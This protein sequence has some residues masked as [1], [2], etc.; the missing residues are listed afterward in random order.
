LGDMESSDQG[1]GAGSDAFGG[2][3]DV[4]LSYSRDDKPQASEILRVL[5]A[6]GIS[7]WWDDM[8]EG[9]TP[10]LKDTEF[11]LEN[12]AT[13]VVLWSKISVN[14]H[15][16]AD[17]ATR[18]RDRGVLIPAT[19]DGTFPPLGFRQFQCLDLSSSDETVRTAQTQ[20][21][22]QAIK[23]KRDGDQ[24][25][26]VAQPA[27]T[28][29]NPSGA[30][31]RDTARA[32]DRRKILVGGGAAMVGAAGLAAWQGGMLDGLLGGDGAVRRVAVMPFDVVGGE[33]EQGAI[34]SNIAREVR[35]KL[36]RNPLLHVAARTSSA[37]LKDAG[38]TARE[39][40]QDLQVDYLL[41]GRASLKGERLDVSGELID[42]LNDRTLLPI[43]QV[44]PVGS[45]LT[46]QGQIASDVIR[47]LTN[48]DELEDKERAGGTDNI[49]AY[50]AFLQAEEL[51][52]AG[53]SEDTDRAALAK[54]DEAI[55]LDPDYAAALALR[56]RTI[57]LIGNL[58][59]EPGTIR[60]SYEEGAQSAREAIRRAPSYAGGHVTL[61]DIL[62]NRQLDMKAAR[63]PFATAAEL[64][65][66]DAGIL[67]GYA[68]YNARIG[69]FASA[70]E[71]IGRATAFDP[72]NAGVFRFAGN[73]EYYSGQYSAAIKRFTDALT[74][75][76]G[77][78]YTNYLIG[79]AQLALGEVAAAKTSFEKEPRF[80]WQKTGLSIAEHRLGNVAVAEA[81]FADLQERQGARS[82]YQYMQVLAQWGEE[83][84]ALDEMDS[85]W[86]ERD[87]GL[88]ELRNDPLL[89][90]LRSNPRFASMLAQIG[91]V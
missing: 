59:G 47:Q 81:H 87:S 54:F 34:L 74:I 31:Q 61:G 23:A 53:V 20:K 78:T 5:E 4:F 89:D 41:T 80:V 60:Q 30:L 17:E 10:F 67:A 73:I 88:I 38:K 29:V 2:A 79:I 7:V 1:K 44:G 15:W 42:G 27:P 19:I 35:T 22:I 16:V 63:E 64:G 62:A 50:D 33:A 39:I 12:A 86:A 72:L 70:R 37:A 32:F 36:S 58:Y 66:G 48:T 18:G 43:S 65:R 91:F 9:G 75:Q 24:G 6:A 69:E 82:H 40:C 76:E 55:G 3:K 11:H 77:G 52:Y 21:L 83:N 13:V 26:P 45:V 71:A 56:G 84:A 8:L 57:A 49:A 85:A 68:V 28:L 46:L 25:A 51:Y 14:S 90:P